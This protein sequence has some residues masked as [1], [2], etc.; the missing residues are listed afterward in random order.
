MSIVEVYLAD[1]LALGDKHVTDSVHVTL[2]PVYAELLELRVIRFDGDPKGFNQLLQLSVRLANDHG[3][4]ETDR[5][6][7]RWRVR[8]RRGKYSRRAQ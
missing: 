1:L 3:L 6:S 2:A 7:Q 8:A 4:E 5:L